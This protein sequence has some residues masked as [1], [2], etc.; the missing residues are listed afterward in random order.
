MGPDSSAGTLAAIAAGILLVVTG[1]AIAARGAL[2]AP[3]ALEGALLLLLIPLLS[4]QGWDY[5]LLIGTPAVVLL[6]NYLPELPRG[7][8]Y[9][10]VGSMATIALSIYDLMGRRAYAA[11]MALS[12]I[13]VLVIVEIAALVALRLRRVA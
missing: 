11:F 6:V 3:D 8:R 4:P 13:T 7:L 12:V 10:T 1:L 2:P 9:A 5:V